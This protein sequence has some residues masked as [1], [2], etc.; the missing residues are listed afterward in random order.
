MF[1]ALELVIKTFNARNLPPSDTPARLVPDPN[2]RHRFEIYMFDEPTERRPR[3]MAH[4]IIV[5]LM[6]AT[7]K[8]PAEEASW[9][10]S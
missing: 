4:M 8:T 5:A 3:T 10:L 2:D 9:L 1:C 7:E 6:K